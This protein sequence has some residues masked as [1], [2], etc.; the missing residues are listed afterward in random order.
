MTSANGQVINYTKTRCGLGH[1]T[2]ARW[3]SHVSVGDALVWW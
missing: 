1:V 3:M 2:L